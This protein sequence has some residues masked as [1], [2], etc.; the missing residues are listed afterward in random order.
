MHQTGKFALSF[1]YKISSSSL[2]SKRERTNFKKLLLALFLI[3]KMAS[4]FM[5][6]CSLTPLFASFTPSAKWQ[7][8]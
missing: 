2:L 6:F 7:F 8:L 1:I 4:K 5:R 3:A